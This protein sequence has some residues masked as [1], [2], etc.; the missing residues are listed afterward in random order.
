MNTRSLSYVAAC[1]LVAAWGLVEMA[2]GPQASEQKTSEKTSSALSASVPSNPCA[3][4]MAM[5]A[6]NEQTA[7][8]LFVAANCPTS[9]GLT[10]ST[11]TEQT[12]LRNPAA[13]T[14]GKVSGHRL[15]ASFLELRRRN[16]SALTSLTTLPACQPMTTKTPD[17]P[18]DMFPFVPANLGANPRFCEEVFVDPNESS[19]V[20]APSP[21]SALSTLSGQVA[22]AASQQ[23][24]VI[25]FPTPAVEIKVDW[26]PADAIKPAFD[27]Q[28]SPPSGVYT[29]LIEGKCYALV[30]LHISSKLLP[31]WLWATFEPQNTSTNPNRCNP[32]LYN[33]CNDPWGSAPST[34]TG[35][36]TEQTADVKA[37]MAAAKLPSAF[38]NYRLVAVQT[39]FVDT[40][41][42]PTQLGNSFVEFNAGVDVHQASCIT[43][44]AYAMLA[45]SQPPAENPNFGGPFPGGPFIG[46]PGPATALP[47]GQKWLSQDFSWM[48]GIMPA[49][50]K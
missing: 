49:T 44:H 1:S 24:G 15:H 38:S 31:N 39:D 33:S 14:G 48:L 23:S 46:T 9:N 19:F 26:L 8:Q 21:N 50:R 17:V 37:L 42:T 13:C 3:L 12:C 32:N 22:Y 28:S 43:C 7:W 18:A 6:N 36:P 10:W 20:T 2:C 5:A 41:K 35:A 45:T 4:P 30:G 34:S 25:T 40:N 27:C 47:D 11:W 16:R 29:E